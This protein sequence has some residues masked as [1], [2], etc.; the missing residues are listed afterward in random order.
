MQSRFDDELTSTF[1]YLRHLEE[2]LRIN[3]RLLL[4]LELSEYMK[5]CKD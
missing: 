3:D 2:K 1:P 5:K 4:L